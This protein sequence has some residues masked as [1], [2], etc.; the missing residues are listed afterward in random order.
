MNLFWF[1][2]TAGDERY[3]GTLQGARKSDLSYLK[4][5]A[6]ALDTLGYDGALLPTGANCEDAWIT[7]SM[8]A[9]VT[10]RIKFL[11]AL[12]PGLMSP[13]LSARMAASFDQLSNGR[14]LLNIVT[15]GN[16]AEQAG[17]GNY[18]DHDQRYDLTDEFLTIWRDVL[19]GKTVDF[20]GKHLSVKGAHVPEQ[21]IQKPYPPI[22]FGGSSDA[23]KRVGLKHADV[24]LLWGEPPAK[25]RKKVEE[26]KKQAKAA[27]KSIRFG[28]R[29]HVIVRETE[30][31]AWDAA[32][33]L[34]QY[35]T[36]ETIESFQQRFSAFDSTAQKTQSSLHRGSRSRKDL[37][38]SPN[39]W[40]GVGLAREG[41]GTAIVGDPDTVA[42][43]LREYEGLGI[44]TFILS[45]Y[46]HLEEA[47]RFA[48]LV[49]PIIK[50]QSAAIREEAI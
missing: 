9:S 13:T 10:A 27:G 32:E 30:Q 8:L 14:L 18:L 36:D 29:M 38:I 22:Y 31:A 4:Q 23:G 12:R 44:D 3:L 26:M 49:F 20:E 2:P 34:I 1:F 47:Y 41:A 17:F 5:I 21:P 42:E 19:Q 11:V 7:A 16:P 35:V 25:I 48:E 50:N 45:G 46:P 37:E 28:L 39:L 40:A 24:H 6:G 43:R 15:G 33:E